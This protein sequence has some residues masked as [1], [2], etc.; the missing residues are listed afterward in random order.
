MNENENAHPHSNCML[1]IATFC[2]KSKFERNCQQFFLKI[3]LKL[4]YITKSGII[5]NENGKQLT[6]N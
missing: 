1:N 6:Q 3:K 4:I 2:I 5:L